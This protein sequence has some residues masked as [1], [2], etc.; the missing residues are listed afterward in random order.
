MNEVKFKPSK[1]LLDIEVNGVKF[2]SGAQPDWKVFASLCRFL[3]YEVKVEEK[4]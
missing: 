3:G 2:Y 1:G 4:A